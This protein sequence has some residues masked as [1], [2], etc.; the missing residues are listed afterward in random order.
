MPKTFIFNIMYEAQI[1]IFKQQLL[2]YTLLQ[3]F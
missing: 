1:D 2:Y 3:H